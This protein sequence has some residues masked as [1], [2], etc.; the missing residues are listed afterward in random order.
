MHPGTALLP[1]RHVL[2]LLAV[3]NYR[4][5]CSCYLHSRHILN[6]QSRNEYL[7]SLYAGPW[8]KLNDSRKISLGANSNLIQ[9]NGKVLVDLKGIWIK[10]ILVPGLDAEKSL[11]LLCAIHCSMLNLQNGLKSLK[12]FWEHQ[13]CQTASEMPGPHCFFFGVVQLVKQT[14]FSFPA[15]VVKRDSRHLKHC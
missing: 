2:P 12:G 7:T 15:W 13:S 3:R 10:W 8:K 11:W 14:C 9:A 1:S 4:C 6:P 5:G